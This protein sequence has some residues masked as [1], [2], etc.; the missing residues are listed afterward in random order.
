M[1]RERLQTASDELRKASELADGGVQERLYE[2]SNQFARLANADRGPDHGRLARHL[3]VLSEVKEELN[4]DALEHL[5][6]AREAIVAY[7][8]TV[9]G[10]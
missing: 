3:N 1:A 10:I 9:E 4:E 6:A 5:E 8:E 2:Q 7:R